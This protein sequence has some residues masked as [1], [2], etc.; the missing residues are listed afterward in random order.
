M[1]L[2]KPFQYW[3]QAILRFN[4][5]NRMLSHLWA[6]YACQ[7][8]MLIIEA[9]QNILA[10]LH[11]NHVFVSKLLTFNLLFLSLLLLH[12]YQRNSEAMISRISCQSVRSFQT[13]RNL[14]K[15]IRSPRTQQNVL[16]V[17]QHS[18]LSFRSGL[19]GN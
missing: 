18:P 19:V 5:N 4:T 13:S 11:V 7:L 9:F 8:K 16:N 17:S 2:Y 3:V 10:F 14:F 6:K 12:N 15:R 1:L